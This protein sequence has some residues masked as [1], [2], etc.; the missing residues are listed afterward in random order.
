MF[1]HDNNNNIKI[2][3]YYILINFIFLLSVCLIINNNNTNNIN[4]K[5]TFNNFIILFKRCFIQK[6]C[7]QIGFDF[8]IRCKVNKSFMLS[9]VTPIPSTKYIII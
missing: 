7:H 3:N 5:I 2:I 8:G 6:S 1:N 4:N 9:I